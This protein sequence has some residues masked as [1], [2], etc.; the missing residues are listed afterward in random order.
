MS[1]SHSLTS[2]IIFSVSFFF[3]LSRSC[4]H[5]T[6]ETQPGCRL[7]DGRGR[8]SATE[9]GQSVCRRL[10]EAEQRPGSVGDNASNSSGRCLD[11]YTCRCATL[12]KG[13][14]GS[15]VTCSSSALFCFFLYVIHP[16]IISNLPAAR[17]CAST[18]RA[19]KQN[20]EAGSC[21]ASCRQLVL[22]PSCLQPPVT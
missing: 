16:E 9:T 5:T 12:L 22:V 15:R 13:F 19:R 1:I 18:G 10:S 7:M 14:V 2:L 4:C 11:T 3:F 21:S 8:R 20:A 6:P 17:N